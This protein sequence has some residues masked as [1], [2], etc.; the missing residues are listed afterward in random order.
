MKKKVLIVLCVVIALALVAL[1]AYRLGMKQKQEAPAPSQS[2][3]TGTTEHKD[4]Q[5]FPT[6]AVD[7]TIIQ[8]LANPDA[9][10]GKK[11]RVIGVGNA[12]TENCSLS[13]TKDDWKYST[14][15]CLWVALD[16]AFLE[17]LQQYNGEYV[18]V[19]GV[20]DKDE[21]GHSDAFQGAIKN[22]SRYE[23]WNA[24][25]SAH[26]KIT[27]YQSFKWLYEITDYDGK[28]LAYKEDLTRE[29][30]RQLVSTDV[31]GICIQAGTGRSTNY[32]QYFDLE[33]SRI[34]EVF[35]YVLT[36]K[37]DYVVRGDLRDGDHYIIVQSIFDKDGFYQEYKLENVS[38]VAA[39]FVT[40]CY[41]N[42]KGNILITYLSGEDYKK[43][44]YSIILPPK[45]L[46]NNTGE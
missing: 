46:E 9:Y 39:D 26:C 44:L 34:S 7:T 19:E 27:Q 32:A 25:I 38:P 41:I 13:L 3:E 16:R 24:N 15:N 42:Q 6:E 11:V 17:E 36:A 23:L 22:I 45:Y 37:D 28:I 43:E 21:R 12:A 30:K 35:H 4:K 14:G 20:F 33:N 29:P 2:G 40:S 1:L 10:D 31:V 8:L 5:N 18:I